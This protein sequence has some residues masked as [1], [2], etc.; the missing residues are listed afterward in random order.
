MRGRTLINVDKLVDKLV[1]IRLLIL[2]NDIKHVYPVT[3][4]GHMNNEYY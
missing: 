1:T 2:S 4:V 3:I